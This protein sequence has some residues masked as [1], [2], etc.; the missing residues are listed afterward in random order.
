MRLAVSLI[1]IKFKKRLY[2]IFIVFHNW[3]IKNE[4]MLYHKRNN[5][6]AQTPKVGCKSIYYDFGILL[7]VGGCRFDKVEI[8]ALDFLIYYAI[9]KV[10]FKLGDAL[11]RRTLKEEL[12][13]AKAVLTILT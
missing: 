6:E 4:H 1:K 8:K 10:E 2:F 12:W 3:C 5:R 11:A 7:T 13:K 9:W